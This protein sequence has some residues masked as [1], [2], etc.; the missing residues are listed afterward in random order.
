MMAP[1]TSNPAEATA[2]EEENLME[3]AGCK[4]T[5]DGTDPATQVSETQQAGPA[6]QKNTLDGTDPAT[7][8]SKTQPT[9]PATQE[10]VKRPRAQQ[11]RGAAIAQ[12]LDYD[13]EWEKL[14]SEKEQFLKMKDFLERAHA[15]LTNAHPLA[16]GATPA[17]PPPPEP[18]PGPKIVDIRKALDALG[19]DSLPPD[20]YPHPSHAKIFSDLVNS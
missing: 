3:S 1:P 6:T 15:F 8:V 9:D 7:Q 11:P 13:L 12:K 14:L 17:L 5:L 19:M 2:D 4:K 20:C 18:L 16:D 10:V